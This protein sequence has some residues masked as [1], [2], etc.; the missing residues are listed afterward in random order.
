MSFDE[1]VEKV[2][3]VTGETKDKIDKKDE[4]KPVGTH[5]NASDETTKDDDQQDSDE[6]KEEEKQPIYYLT[7]NVLKQLQSS[8]Y[9]EQFK[10]TDYDVLLMDDP[11]DEWVI[12]SLPAYQEYPLK[13]AMS[14]DLDLG[15]DAKQQEKKKQDIEKKAKE[16]KNLL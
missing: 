3:D 14:H 13:S 6:P 10:G 11:I 15:G 4:D 1:Y 16:H 2:T 9:L 7:G 12:Q 5:S 8:P